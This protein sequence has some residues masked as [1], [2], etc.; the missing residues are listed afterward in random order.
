ME[1]R[2]RQDDHHWDMVNAHMATTNEVLNSIRTEL[3]RINDCKLIQD[4]RINNLEKIAAKA[5]GGTVVAGVI[6]GALVSF[7][8][9]VVMW[10]RK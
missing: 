6:G 8:T 2:R 1:E 9:V 5:E 7:I 4:A 10:F 3:S